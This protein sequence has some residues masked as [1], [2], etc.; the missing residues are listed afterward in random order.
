VPTEADV[1]VAFHES[2]A[3]FVELVGSIDPARYGD[4]GTGEWT[5]LELIAHTMRAFIAIEEVLARTLDPASRRL[6]DAA[7]YYRTAM[8]IPG[9][10]DGISER[11]RDGVACIEDDPSVHVRSL[12]DRV[13][14]LVDATP[15]VR[16]VQHYV[17]RI[18]FG[19]YLVTRIT[20]LVLHSVDLQVAVGYEP[21]SP[22]RAV[23]MVCDELLALADRVDALA[24]ACALSGRGL[25]LACD[26]LA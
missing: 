21:S 12:A 18:A 8:S 10:H 19:D 24:V 4:P 16:E 15:V 13:G 9:V 6:A 1:V 17:G 25:A 11:A 7:D 23:A 2:S 3:S 5:V 26:V 22:P 14:A 20:E